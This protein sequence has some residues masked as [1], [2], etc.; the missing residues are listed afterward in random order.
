M[1]RALALGDFLT[2]V[3]A[4][5]ALRRAY[6]EHR[7]TLA[8]PGSFAPLLPLVGAVDAVVPVTGLGAPPPHRWNPEVAVNL[9]GR[10]PE[11][12]AM[13]RETRAGRIVGFAH[14]D[15][16]EVAGPDWRADEH[17]VARWCRL[18]EYH[19]VPADPAD[20]GLARPPMPSMVQNAVLV[21]PGAG[22]P[23]RRWPAER[24]ALAAGELA[25]A[26]HRVVVTGNAAER[27]LAGRVA[28]RA[29]LPVEAVLAGRTD[30]V[31]LAALVA[32]AA[33][34]VSGDTGVAHLATAYRV[35]S[36]L[37]FGPTSPELWGPPD[38]DRHRVLWGGREP[39]DRNAP[40]PDPSLL[41][42]T[43]DEVL[44]AAGRALAPARA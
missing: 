38:S 32:D 29:G 10:G 37:V 23:S 34:V 36:V 15:F 26:G 42:V 17:E 9:H 16:P 6:P 43:V 18:L 44:D 28:R 24:F 7:I 41:D 35:P 33:L 12:H 5:R 2:A 20:L 40:G 3:P 25:R 31:G 21:H 30:L 13:L 27:D 4:L 14:P 39:G 1:L 19:D 11:S 22:Q 8:A